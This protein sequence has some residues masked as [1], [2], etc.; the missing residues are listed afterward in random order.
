M[1]E[2]PCTTDVAAPVAVA[3]AATLSSRLSFSSPAP[4]TEAFITLLIRRIDTT[5]WSN[6]DIMFWLFVRRIVRAAAWDFTSSYFLVK[7]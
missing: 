2:R 7:P 4:C 3:A 1:N 6:H 5:F